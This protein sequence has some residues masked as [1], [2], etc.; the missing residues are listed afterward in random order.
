LSD[1]QIDAFRQQLDKANL[2]F[3]REHRSND[4]E[5]ARRKAVER[6]T[7][8]QLRDWVGP[9]SG[10]QEKQ[11]SK[12]LLEVPLTDRLRHEDRLRRQQEFLALLKLRRGDRQAFTQRLRDWLQHW[13]SG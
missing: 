4:G 5:A 10:A 3:L 11:I 12:L 13:E 8:A 6:R 7:L 9:L 2:K 1:Q